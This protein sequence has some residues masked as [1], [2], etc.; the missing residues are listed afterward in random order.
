M[1]VP[2]VWSLLQ[3]MADNPLLLILAPLAFAGIGGAIPHRR[4]RKRRRA[5]ENALPDM[6]ESMSDGVG[7]GQGVAQALQSVAD[8]RD[9]LLGKM[10]KQAVKEGREAGFTASI[11]QFSLRTRSVQVQRVMNLLV[12]AIEQDAPLQDVL[13]RMSQEY[14]RL[15]LLMNKRETE[16]SGRAILVMVFVVFML[17][18]IIGFMV[19]LLA[20]PTTGIDAAPVNTLL[21][22]F[23]GIAAVLCAGISGRMLGRLKSSLW[24]LPLWGLVAMTW[25]LVLYQAVGGLGLV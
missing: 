6:L 1:V 23:F 21:G 10:L 19:A 16:M 25:Y 9:D 22:T 3:V 4:E 20:G 12:T 7:A 2:I 24:T 11:A 8:M 15:N 17:P 5:I 13:F 18:A 14:T